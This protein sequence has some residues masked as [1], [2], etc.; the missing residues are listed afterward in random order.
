MDDTR[1]FPAAH[2][3]DSGWFA[4]DSQGALAH[5]DTGEA[6]ALMTASPYQTGESGTKE[7]QVLYQNYIAPWLAEHVPPQEF[8][9]CF[10]GL[11][12]YFGTGDDAR[13]FARGCDAV[14][15][16]V[17]HP[18][19]L[20]V[21]SDSH[22][23]RDRLYD[24]S[25]FRGLAPSS[26]YEFMHEFEA[27]IMPLARYTHGDWCIPGHYIRTQSGVQGAELGLCGVL[28]ELNT[29]FDQ[30]PEIQLADIAEEYDFVCW[31]EGGLKW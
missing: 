1:D 12:A 22:K 14:D 4:I 27:S 28:P 31:G 5:F 17:G 20:V 13:M 16:L 25:G 21:V 26:F 19:V 9:V 3:M 6:G 2:S 24:T 8:A 15:L 11:L 23:L 7:S 10:L 30:A 29:V 18:E